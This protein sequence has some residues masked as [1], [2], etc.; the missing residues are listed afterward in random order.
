[1][2]HTVVNDPSESDFNSSLRKES[3]IDADVVITVC[4]G[5]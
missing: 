5:D 2:T 1:M 4:D 3:R